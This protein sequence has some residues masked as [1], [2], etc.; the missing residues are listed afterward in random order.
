MKPVRVLVP[1]SSANLGPGF[2]AFGLALTLYNAVEM[3]EDDETHVV[4]S[5]EGA[6]TLAKNASNLVVRAAQRLFDAAGVRLRGLR[7]ALHNAIPLGR[8]LGSSAAAIVGGLVA[9]NELAHRPLTRSDLLKL[10]VQ[11]EGHPDNVAPALLGGLVVASAGES[12]LIYTQ[13]PLPPMR[14]VVAIPDFALP[15]R[16]ARAI[17]PA[18]VPRRDAVFNLAR[19]ALVLLALQRGD[20]D[21][22]AQAMDDRLHQPYRARLIPGMETVFAAARAAGAAGV[23]LSGAGPSLIAFAEGD[24]ECIGEAMQRAWAL[25]GVQ[26]RTL[27]LGVDREG[28][29]VESTGRGTL[30]RAPT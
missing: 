30:Q 4:I 5:G 24:H 8:G 16:Q 6:A 11:M 26:A 1:A 22:L 29:R 12:D 21:L 15:T 17:L 14:V 25:Q 20:Y 10:A 28:A 9:A 18:S 19:A 2:D 13:V 23:A 3:Q 27:V 7:L